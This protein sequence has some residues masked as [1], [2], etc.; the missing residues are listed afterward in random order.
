MIFLFPRSALTQPADAGTSSTSTFCT[1]EYA[2][3][4]A[5]LGARVSEMEHQP[6]SQYSY[7]IRNTATYECLSYGVEGNVRRTRKKVVLHGTG[8]GYRVQNGETYL[9]TNNHVAEWPTVTDEEHPVEDVPN[10]CKKVGEALRIVDNENDEYER[11]DIALTRVVGDPL[12]DVAVLKAPTLLNVLPWKVGRSA[13]LRSR[14]VVEV[15]GF[16]LGAFRATNVGK[17]ISAYDHDDYKDYDHVDFVIDALLSQGNSGSPVLAV[18]CKTGEFELVGIYH[19]RYTRGNA[20][21]VVVGIDQVRDLMTTFKRS[22]RVATA[23][24]Q[25]LDANDRARLFQTARASLEPFFP[26]GPLTAAVHSRTDGALIFELFSRD[27]P[28]KAAPIVVIEDLPGSA[29]A[30]FGDLNRIWFGGL[31]GLKGYARTDFDADTLT[32]LGRMLDGFRRDALTAFAYRDAGRDAATSRQRFDDAGKLEKKLAKVSALRRDQ[33][34][35]ASELADRYAPKPTEPSVTFADA[36]NLPV[37]PAI[38]ARPT[39]PASSGK[40]TSR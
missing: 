34:Q 4:F 29:P 1:G 28:L 26:F 17:V 6:Q 15:R 18:S 27:F 39:D 8:F 35:A 24:G 37:A 16:P 13:A 3:D 19:A 22:P 14:N 30:S 40:S 9:L 7:C 36:M 11:D 25:P 5:M 23:D 33:A 21:H 12:L 20:L 38:A 31:Q 10:G 2:D 32:Q